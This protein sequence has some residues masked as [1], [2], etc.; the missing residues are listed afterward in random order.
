MSGLQHARERRRHSGFRL[1]KLQGAGPCIPVSL[2]EALRHPHE[3]LARKRFRSAVRSHFP[4]SGPTSLPRTQYAIACPGQ[5]ENAAIR[6]DR[7]KEHRPWTWYVTLL[8]LVSF[9]RLPVLHDCCGDD[10]LRK[11][12]RIAW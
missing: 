6:S 10:N 4:S 12:N 9:R 5:Q 3:A 8:L 11:A 7:P 1:G 2:T